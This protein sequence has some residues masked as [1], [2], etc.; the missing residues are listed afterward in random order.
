MLFFFKQPLE[1]LPD[2]WAS[3]LTRSKILTKTQP[4]MKTIKDGYFKSMCIV[5]RRFEE[6]VEN[7]MFLFFSSQ[8]WKHFQKL[9]STMFKYSNWVL[10]WNVFFSCS[11][12]N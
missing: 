8:I 4:Q 1:N 2:T 11:F 5:T 12:L 7:L 10:I 3:W 9:V 6:F